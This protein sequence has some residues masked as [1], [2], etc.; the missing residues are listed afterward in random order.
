MKTVLLAL[1]LSLPIFAFEMA[2]GTMYT[3]W[4]EKDST[5]NGAIVI[6]ADTITP[7]ERQPVQVI[8]LVDISRESAGRVRQGLI[9]GGKKLIG[10]LRDGDRFGIVLYSQFA[11]TLFPL[12]ALDTEKRKE[13]IDLLERITTEEGRDMSSA[14]KKVNSEFLLRAGDKIDGRYLVVSSLGKI[15][16]GEKGQALLNE[17]VAGS[18]EDSTGYS[19]YTVGYGEEFDEDVMIKSA[20]LGHGRAFFC[21]KDRPDSLLNIFQDIANEVSRPVMKNVEVFFT[22]PDSDV[23]MYYHGTNTPIPNPYKIRQLSQGKVY[24]ILFTMKNRPE[25]SSALDVDVDYYSTMGKSVLSSTGGTKITTSTEPIYVESMSPPLIQYSVLENLAKSYVMFRRV[26]REMTP[27]EAKEFRR[28]YA[29]GFQKGV[30]NPIEMVRNEINTPEMTYTYLMVKLIFEEIRDGVYENEY[31]I[32][33]VKYNLH[34]T[35][36]GK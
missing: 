30:L 2:A 18:K 3:G 25:R 32:R 35:I 27:K 21:P 36:H 15:T 13:A 11:R 33:R 4:P 16:E 24:R 31:I 26:D 17:L 5:L 8:Y 9:E 29:F 6:K 19:L 10:T 22:F 14:L 20:E 23:K 28:N 34:H 12:T 7:T 1:L